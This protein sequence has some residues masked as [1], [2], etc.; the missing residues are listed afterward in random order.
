MTDSILVGDVQ[1]F[2]TEDGPGIRTTIFLKGCP[3]KCLW[4]HNPELIS[5]EQ[6]II[7]RSSRCIGCRCCIDACTSDA[8]SCDD[9][10][11][12]I[13]RDK[14]KLCLECTKV[15]YA[16][17]LSPVAERKSIEDLI[18]IVIKDREYYRQTSG[19]VTISG[20]EPLS[21]FDF[22]SEFIDACNSEGLEICIDTSGFGEAEKLTELALK[23]NVTNILFD[24]KCIDNVR[25]KELT[26]VDN[27]VILSN[28]S[29][30]AGDDRTL[31]KLWIRMP[32]IDGVNDSTDIINRTAEFLRPLRIPKLTLI[33]YHPFGVMKNENIGVKGIEYKAPSSEKLREIKEKLEVGDGS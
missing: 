17:A 24:I 8:V 5:Y 9:G 10:I 15:C 3:L 16:G 7:R 20:G 32:M 18:E 21:H 26:S 1:R 22:V 30:L 19:G 25:H 2:S 12:E 27:D 14:C 33:P 23:E 11:I 6:Q 13:D 31:Q 29:M 4:C 28:L